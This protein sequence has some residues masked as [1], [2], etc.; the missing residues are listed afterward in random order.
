MARKFDSHHYTIQKRFLQGT[1]LFASG[2][3]FDN[4]E[5][6]GRLYKPGQ[7]NNAYIFPGIALGCVLFKAK[8]IPDKLFLLAARR[9]ADAV[10]E[11]S[12][13][14]YSRL[15]PRLK[16]IRELSIH[17]AVEVG[18]Y[19]YSHNLATLHPKPEDME[20][21]IRQHVYSVEYTD[22]INKTYDWPAKDAKHGFPVPVLRRSSMDDE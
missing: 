15:F 16:D 13:V 3:P 7:G 22:L 2:S 20:L 9:V 21:F 4:V 10:T 1:V 6:D 18:E 8:H 14:T 17:I 11:K 19:L 12:L 5:I